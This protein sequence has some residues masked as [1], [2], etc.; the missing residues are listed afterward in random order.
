MFIV[1]SGKFWFKGDKAVEY[2]QKAVDIGYKTG[3]RNGV[4]ATVVV[5]GAIILGKK[6][7]DKK[8]KKQSEETQ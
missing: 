7:Y 6:V 4:I 2:L 8:T 3:F 1:D 5:S